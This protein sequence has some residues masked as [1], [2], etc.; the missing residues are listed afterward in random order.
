MVTPT[1][2]ANITWKA[3]LVFMACVRII[4]YLLQVAYKLTDC[5][6]ELLLYPNDLLSLPRD[7]GA[8]TGGH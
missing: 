7:Q 6:A 4:Q 3:Y 8:Y 1:M 2:I 5:I